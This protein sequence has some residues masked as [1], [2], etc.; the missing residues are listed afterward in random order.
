MTSKVHSVPYRS[1]FLISNYYA[2]VVK[3]GLEPAA[4]RASTERST[5]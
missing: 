3:A 4:F 2:M 1:Y 5:N